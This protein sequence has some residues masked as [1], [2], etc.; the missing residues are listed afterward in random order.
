MG[1]RGLEGEERLRVLLALAVEGEA[2]LFLSP[3]QRLDQRCGGRGGGGRGRG[4]GGGGGGAK[5][6]EGVAELLKV[7]VLFVQLGLQGG[8]GG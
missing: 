8:D 5:D 1:G 3:H 4:G 2:E 7:E 6:E